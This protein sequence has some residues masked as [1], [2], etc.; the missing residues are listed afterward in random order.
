M[1][2][3]FLFDSIYCTGC[4]T[5]QAACKD[6]NHLPVGVLWRRVYEITGAGNWQENEGTWTSDVYAYNISMACNHCEFPKCAGVCPTQAYTIFPDGIVLLDTQRCTGCGYCAWA[7]PYGAPQFNEQAGVMTKC[8]FCV[9]DLES[10]QAP[11][12]VSACPMRTLDFVE[13]PAAE[14]RPGYTQQ[15]PPMPEP[16]NRNPRFLIKPHPAV[17][18]AGLGDAHI[19]N[20]EEV[21]PRMVGRFQ[22]APLVAFTLLAQM[23]VGAFFLIG[24]WGSLNRPIGTSGF[25][26]NSPVSLYSIGALVLISLLISFSHL[27]NPK[28]A[29]RM[30]SHLKKSW[31]SREILFTSLFGIFWAGTVILEVF[32]VGFFLQL[33][34]WAV[35]S[36][37][38][39]AAIWSMARV[40]QLK[41]VPLWNT[42][43]TAAAFFIS[44][45]LLGSLWTGMLLL[46]GNPGQL[47]YSS[48]A[49][50]TALISALIF[51]LALAISHTLGNSRPHK[52][53]RLRTGLI[54]AGFLG[55]IVVIVL[56]FMF[57]IW[58]TGLVFIV[59]VLEEVLGRI[60]FYESRT[61]MF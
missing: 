22:E 46:F 57:G 2:T 43:Y 21:K 30:L 52:F 39:L 34:M 3:T 6:K 28:N 45:F 55:S 38:G 1:A 8:N 23:A 25:F 11:A 49:T 31:L 37:T 53:Q 36:L 58:I 4:K 48:Y 15:I 60:M 20:H 16:D 18:Q 13:L 32:N 33:I 27:G 17:V 7:C 19:S 9:D 26:Q 42:K 10:G 41:T 12:C 50:V 56:P 5:C 59:A 24:I 44:T 35:T 40:Y 61:Q 29:W 47:I 51:I 54:L 14:T